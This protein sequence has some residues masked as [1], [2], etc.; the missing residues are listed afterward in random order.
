MT[1]FKELQKMRKLSTKA[2]YIKICKEL[3]IPI[4]NSMKKNEIEK[5]LD[6]INDFNI[7]IN[8]E[9]E[10]LEYKKSHN[11]KE[12]QKIIDAPQVY[13]CPASNKNME[14]SIIN[15]F[16][17]EYMWAYNASPKCNFLQKWNNM[18]IGSLCVFGSKFHGYTKAA[19]VIEKKNL[20]TEEKDWPFKGIDKDNQK[21]WS[22]GFILS[23]P[24]DINISKKTIQ[25]NIR[26]KN[27][28]TQILLDEKCANNLKKILML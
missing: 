26:Q 21:D 7:L 22:Y 1:T 17:G 5:I 12:K 10:R 6:D 14:I 27:W 23:E 3:N 16:N 11:K 24:F 15:R 13:I 4:S 28:L 19:Y 8:N 2:D 25:D 18:E 9:K 20:N